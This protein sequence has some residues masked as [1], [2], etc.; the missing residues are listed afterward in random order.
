VLKTQR[1]T[2]KILQLSAV[3]IRLEKFSLAG[4]LGQPTFLDNERQ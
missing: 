3:G 1:V 2:R 4:L